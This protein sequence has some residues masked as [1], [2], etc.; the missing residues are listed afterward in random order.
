MSFILDALKKSESERQR[1]AG[2]ALFE[3]RIAPPRSRF[4]AW[5][6]ALVALLA[7]NVV[8]VAWLLLRPAPAVTQAAAPAPPLPQPS[9]PKQPDTAGDLPLAVATP[10]PAPRRTRTPEPAAARR[11]D[12]VAQET[13]YRRRAV[14]PEAGPAT[15]GAGLAA[16]PVLDEE[17]ISLGELNP[18]DYEPAVEPGAPLPASQRSAP[19]VTTGLPSYQQVAASA[20]LN[21]PQ[22][23][24]DL[25]VYADDPQNRFVLVNMQRLS[26][27][28]SLPQG[29]QVESIT[30]DGVV[31]SYRGTRFLLTR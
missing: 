2:P 18:D 9:T 22:L 27:G 21:F 25:H 23:S 5:A 8:I 12:N 31:M 7:I 14:Q 13:A 17:E 10:E 11:P 30:P 19:S 6:I 1:Q 24:L 4:P 20:G 3:V 29:V 26:E 28:D 15:P 16:E